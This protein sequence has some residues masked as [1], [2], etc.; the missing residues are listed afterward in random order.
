MN[1]PLNLLATAKPRAEALPTPVQLR[2][3]LPLDPLLTERVHQQR[4][5]I[6]AIL[7]GRDPRLL[8]VIGPCSLH[9]PQSALDYG[10]RL[11][12][13]QADVGDQLLL[14]MRAYLEK[15]RTTVGWK[16]L[17]FDPYLDGS[18][19]ADEGLRLSRGLLLDLLRLGLPL[20]SELLQPLAAAYI[21]DLLGWAAIGARTSESQ[22]HREMVSGLDLPVGFKNGTD[23]GLTIACDAMQAAAQGHRH[24][25]LDEH[26]QPALLHSPGNPHS[27]LVLRG[28]HLGPNYAAEHVANARTTLAKRGL[29][30]S[31]MIDCSHANSGKD[32]QRQPEVLQAV[33]QQ[34]LAGDT[35]LRAVMLESHLVGGCQPLQQP[36]RYGQSITDACLGWDASDALLRQAAEQ[37]RRGAEA[38]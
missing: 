33:L 21:D 3:Q 7:E 13:L 36:L 37:L 23:G 14:V 12:A 24:F 11:A 26:G 32:A 2:Q 31:I 20:A 30:Q 25:G 6:R 10:Q 17:L 19:T 1:A 16:G 27:H 28:G 29:P 38:F 5:A 18:G 4:A 22:V 15:P 35:A 9:D 34:R 8:V